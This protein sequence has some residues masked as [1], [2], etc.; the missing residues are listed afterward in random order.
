MSQ[1]GQRFS[2]GSTMGELRDGSRREPAVRSRS[3]ATH[4]A[5]GGAA[6]EDVKSQA[7]MREYVLDLPDPLCSFY[8]EAEALSEVES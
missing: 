5:A 6:T 7:A 8:H 4:A 1:Q 3:A 2:S